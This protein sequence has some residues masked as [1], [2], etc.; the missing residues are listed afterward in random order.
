MLIT[1]A[2]PPL[3]DDAGMRFSLDFCARLTENVPCYNLDFAPNK[4][5]VDFI[6]CIC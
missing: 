4:N 3:W 5:I 2:F 6:R 1:R